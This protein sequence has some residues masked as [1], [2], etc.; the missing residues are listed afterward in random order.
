MSSP[1]FCGNILLPDL[2][3]APSL[4]S[5]ASGNPGFGTG[6]LLLNAQGI[7]WQENRA[8]YS[9]VKTRSWNS[10]APPRHCW[11]QP[12]LEPALV[13]PVH[14]LPVP[15]VSCTDRQ[16]L[17]SQ[18]LGAHPSSLRIACFLKSLGD[19]LIIISPLLRVEEPKGVWYVCVYLLFSDRWKV[20]VT[21]RGT[22]RDAEKHRGTHNQGE[23]CPA[24][25]FAT[26]QLLS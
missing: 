12:A 17:C 20:M 8:W 2:A 22:K 6:C 7:M 13:T 15:T 4:D 21:D 19:E 11:H 16:S 18:G 9:A 23:S 3:K 24:S 25:P 14:L 1:V 26:L 5:W 10:K